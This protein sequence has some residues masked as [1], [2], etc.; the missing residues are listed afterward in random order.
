MEGWP[1][2]TGWYGNNFDKET[3]ALNGHQP[4]EDPTP[5]PRD[6]CR[7]WNCYWHHRAKVDIYSKVSSSNSRYFSIVAISLSALCILGKLDIDSLVTWLPCWPM[8]LAAVTLSFKR[9][10]LERCCL[11]PEEVKHASGFP[12]GPFLKWAY[13]WPHLQET[14]KPGI[15]D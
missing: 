14:V 3:R 2:L 5:W 4:S 15:S 10:G 13:M 1:I 12:F 11:V 7:F 9:W 8:S 6:T